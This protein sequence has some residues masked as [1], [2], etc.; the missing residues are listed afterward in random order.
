MSYFDLLPDEMI[1]EQCEK[2]DAIS[3]E[4][5]A[6]AYERM[7]QVCG[8][9]IQRK[10]KVHNEVIKIM[11]HIKSGEFQVELHEK[12][13]KFIRDKKVRTEALEY[14]DEN[15]DRF[16]SAVIIEYNWPNWYIIFSGYYLFDEKTIKELLV[17]L[18]E[19]N[20]TVDVHHVWRP[21]QINPNHNR[22]DI[23]R[24]QY[25]WK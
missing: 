13:I 11:N 7:S 4:N 14:L 8:D 21:I 20:E 9:I 5:L 6:M 25:Q 17:D 15:G 1:V 23:P 19:N 18:I 3:L 16:G 22:I 24:H 10:M 2:M 12:D